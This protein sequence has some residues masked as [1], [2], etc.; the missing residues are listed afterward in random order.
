M[1]E[2]LTPLIVA[3]AFVAWSYFQGRL[4]K[5]VQPLRLKMAE[6]GE[7]LLARSDIS[8]QTRKDVEFMLSTAFSR[9][10]MLLFAIV[11]VPFAI[12]CVAFDD[13]MRAQV[14]RDYSKMTPEA[15]SQYADMRSL[16]GR[17]VMANHPLLASI[18]VLEVTVLL[19]PLSL[20]FTAF[21][22]ELSTAPVDRYA[23]INIV[24]MQEQNIVA[25]FRKRTAYARC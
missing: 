25:K 20:L 3:A 24:E 2:V 1:F 4:A 10:G 14:E 18:V 11:V 22:R 17:V 5:A 23:F 6:Q 15:R 8:E 16:H 9:W 12:F 19:V 21:K 7:A 13:K